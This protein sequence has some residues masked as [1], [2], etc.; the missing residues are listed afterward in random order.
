MTK[1]GQLHAGLFHCCRLRAGTVAARESAA[2][3][4]PARN[5]QIAYTVEYK[6]VDGTTTYSTGSATVSIVP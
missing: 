6:L 1:K 2:K 5:G 3:K 4:G